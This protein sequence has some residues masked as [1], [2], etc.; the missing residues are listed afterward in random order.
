M[1]LSINRSNGPRRPCLLV[2]DDNPHNLR[3]LL[4]V[5]EQRGYEVRPAI[6]GRLALR[7]AAADPPD[8]V[9][10]D[11]R[12]PD[13]DGYEVCRR[14]KLD[15]K[16][17]SIPV[18][19][20]SALEEVIDKVA[21]F[22]AGGVDFVS[23]PFQPE[24]VS[25]RVAAHLALAAQQR[26]LAEQVDAQTVALRAELAL[27]QALS[28]L[29]EAL[30]G[31]SESIESS[32]ERSLA[33]AIKL[34]AP[35]RAV[36]LTI[37][38][39]NPGTAALPVV[40]ARFGD[41]ALPEQLGGFAEGWIGRRHLGCLST[42]G[43]SL[44]CNRVG[45]ARGARCV[46]AVPVIIDGELVGQ[47]ILASSTRCF[48]EAEL[49]VVQR[50]ANLYAAAVGRHRAE[51][52]AFHSEARFR[53][54]YEHIVDAILVC[55]AS[56]RVVDAN[57][58]ACR[59]LG[60]E[61]NELVGLDIER[62]RA[63]GGKVAVG[64]TSAELAVLP[65]GTA[66]ETE[67]CRNDGLCYP[68][69][70]RLASMPFGGASCLVWVARDISARKRA[71][72]EKQ[73]L[74]LQ[75]RQA[76]KMEAIG[77]LAGGIAHDFNNILS[78]ICGF[79]QLA[80]CSIDDQELVSEHLEE[81]FKAGMRA[82]DLVR[83][84]LSFS[85][86]T[87]RDRQPIEFQLVLKE[88][89]RFLKASLPST[90]QITTEVP[91]CPPVLGDPTELHQV[92]MNLCTNS[93][94]A[95]RETGGKLH[96][97]LEHD[98]LL[99]G[100]AEE[101]GL[102]GGGYVVLRVHDTGCGIP[103]ESLERIFEPYFTTKGQGEGTGLGLAVVH[104]IVEGCGGRV[105]VESTQG[106]GTTITVWL[107]VAGAP[108]ALS[109]PESGEPPRAGAGERVMVVDDD[110]AVGLLERRILEGLGYEV[111]LYFDSEEALTV[112]ADAPDSF[113]LLVTDMT[114]PKLTG[115]ELIRRISEIRPGMRTILCTG[116]SDLVDAES[117][118]E[119]GIR[120]FIVKPIIKNELGRA[121]RRALG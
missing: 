105:A 67:F 98:L 33:H 85:R 91:P 65:D 102:K 18:I 72:A 49:A 109:T 69:E 51:E 23:K 24:E 73:Q 64:P 70:A 13:M 28:E 21:A 71:A 120:E 41:T 121:V 59:D 31:E 54:L 47:L 39:D 25:S 88:S 9:L 6:N 114:M 117:A 110:V 89:M 76:Q 83:Q 84:I 96:V 97:T 81:V 27:N 116:Y 26:A 36:L 53:S 94:H 55:G 80:Q 3:L 100:A 103:P 104:G 45:G 22:E 29:A 61:K 113:D 34:V 2:V 12:M 90:I 118:R 10:L 112:L 77:T 17:E 4:Q 19:F 119:A 93:Y 68:V 66:F 32:A 115:I 99:D 50:L 92:V 14:L 107:P 86:R 52:A 30:V 60:Y 95:M 58:A 56:G 15:P 35:E 46:L 87:E 20:I 8:L 62:I 79:T 111:A 7:S 75:L 108:V 57:A 63:P 1:A 40:Q 43:S 78:A 5:L 37:D 11:V 82:R 106:V 16:T 38:H 48:S 74:E 44:P 101:L 42:D